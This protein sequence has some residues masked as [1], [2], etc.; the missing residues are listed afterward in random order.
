MVISPGM[1]GLKLGRKRDP[2]KDIAEWNKL[3]GIARRKGSVYSCV[4]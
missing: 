3:K 4:S 2:V 1:Q